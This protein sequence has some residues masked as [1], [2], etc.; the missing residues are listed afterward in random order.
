MG[1]T[2]SGV[3]EEPLMQRPHG[4]LIIVSAYLYSESN[5]TRMTAARITKIAKY[6][7]AKIYPESGQGAGKNTSWERHEGS[8]GWEL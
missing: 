8:V 4:P 7:Q 3:S 5:E 1:R 2:A 6:R